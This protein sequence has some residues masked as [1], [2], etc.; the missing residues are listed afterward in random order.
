MIVTL[1]LCVDKET[2]WKV[3]VEEKGLKVFR[4]DADTA[5]QKLVKNA[6]HALDAGK[7]QT[8]RLEMGV[9]LLSTGLP[10]QHEQSADVRVQ[11]YGGKSPWP[12]PPPPAPQGSDLAT[13]SSALYTMANLEKLGPG[14]VGFWIEVRGVLPPDEPVVP[15][16]SPVVPTFQTHHSSEH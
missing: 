5:N 10:V 2:D 12:P 4:I 16:K 1:V 15:E 14:G 6:V 8:I 11:V 3:V 7:Q 13:T 9:Y